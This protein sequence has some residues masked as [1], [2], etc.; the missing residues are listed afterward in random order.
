MRYKTAFRLA[1]KAIGVYLIVESLMGL[2]T[3][4]AYL[5][6]LSLSGTLGGGGGF[7]WYFQVIQF[8]HPIGALVLGLYLF[9]GGRWIV[10]LAI[11]S[12]RPYCHECGYELRGLP[13]EGECPECGVAYRVPAER[14][15]PQSNRERSIEPRNPA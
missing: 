11:P 13:A 8:V 1:V 7:D 14:R 2:L 12:N 4:S 10:N 15:E 9:F 3:A 5:T 6:S